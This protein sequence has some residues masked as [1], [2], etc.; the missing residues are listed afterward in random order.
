MLDRWDDVLPRF[1]KVVPV[2]YRRVLEA[3]KV[4]AQKHAQQKA[5]PIHG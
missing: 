3:R 1:V 2:E 5:A 4:A